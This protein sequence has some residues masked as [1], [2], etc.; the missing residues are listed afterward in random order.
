MGLFL[1]IY[2]MYIIHIYHKH[3]RAGGSC[4]KKNGAAW[5]SRLTEGQMLL[6]LNTGVSCMCFDCYYRSIVISPFTVFHEL[7]KS[8]IHRVKWCASYIWP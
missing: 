7:M 5:P 1:Y 4:K 6:T 2:Y 3:N 8:S